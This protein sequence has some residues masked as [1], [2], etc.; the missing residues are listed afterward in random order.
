MFVELTDNLRPFL[1][2]TDPNTSL[3]YRLKEGVSLKKAL[4]AV[5]KTN[6]EWLQERDKRI[7]DL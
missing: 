3:K 5:E 6:T 7:S 1:F 2:L 4:K